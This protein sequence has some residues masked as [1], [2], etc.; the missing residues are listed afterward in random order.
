MK[1]VKETDYPGWLD[2][3]IDYA[4]SNGVL[5]VAASGNDALPWVSH[6]ANHPNVWAV[7]AVNS[8]LVNLG[9]LTP[10]KN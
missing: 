4:V 3:A 8:S 6:P 10:V 2:A 5:V 7:G 9:F 1:V